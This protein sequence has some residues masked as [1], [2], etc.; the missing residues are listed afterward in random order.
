M[1]RR[2]LLTSP[3]P[4]M[5]AC[6]HTATRTSA[7][8]WPLTLARPRP[9]AAQLAVPAAGLRER[10]RK[11][12]RWW[13]SCTARANAAPIWHAVKVHGP[14]RH[15]EQGRDYPF[16]LC[17]PQLEEGRDWEPDDLHALI[18]ALQTRLRIDATRICGTGL[19]LGGRRLGLGRGLPARPGRHRAGVRLWR[20]RGRLP[21]AHGAGARLPRRSRHRGAAGRAAG[22]RGRACA[23]AAARSNSRST[24]GSATTPGTRLTKTPNWCPG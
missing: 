1:H 16:V 2:T 19:S 3:L 5:T 7:S 18:G 11:P 8:R 15:V 22:L 17:S 13:S 14:P 9:A 12:G 20:P 6:T 10:A 4:M 21:G 24:P 23:P